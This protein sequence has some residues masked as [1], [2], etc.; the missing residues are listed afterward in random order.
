VIRLDVS[1]YTIP[2]DAPEADG[3]L[4]W[5]STTLV[6]VEANAGDLETILDLQEEASLSTQRD[7]FEP[8]GYPAEA[9]RAR[10]RTSFESGQTR[11]MVAE[12]DGAIVGVSIAAA[13]W[14]F[15]VHVRQAY[16]GT[17]VA[18]DLADEVMDYVRA[19]GFEEVLGWV[20]AENHRSRR[21]MERLGWRPDGGSRQFREPPHP[22]MLRYTC[23]LKRE[24][25]ADGTWPVG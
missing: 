16:W 18:V 8:V 1:A 22:L 15:G 21:F 23:D 25:A 19:A 10:W 11:F 13:P 7:I 3:T 9:I 5:T 12:S 2:T 24:K 4:E 17:G 14:L 20:L 6:L